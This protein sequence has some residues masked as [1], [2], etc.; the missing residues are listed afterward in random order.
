MINSK[1]YKSN[2]TDSIMDELKKIKENI[3]QLDKEGKMNVPV[4]VYA[5]D[6]LLKALIH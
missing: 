2:F 5:S 6:K 1:Q 4:V 3:Y